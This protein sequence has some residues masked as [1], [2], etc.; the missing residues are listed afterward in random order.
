MTWRL[1]VVTSSFR[2]DSI[3]GEPFKGDTCT[4]PGGLQDPTLA[5]HNAKPFQGNSAFHLKDTNERWASGSQRNLGPCG[6]SGG[7]V[8]VPRL[9]HVL[10][11]QSDQSTF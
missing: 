1:G 9:P 3:F 2:W 8:L 4:F 5:P 7:C 11:S 6:A 10:A